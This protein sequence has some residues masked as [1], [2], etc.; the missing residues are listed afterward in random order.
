M[1]K[2]IKILFVVAII[3]LLSVM[4]VIVAACG[5]TDPD[6]LIVYTNSGSGGRSEWWEQQAAEA[7]FK[8]RVI[9][10][11][12]DAMKEK[13]IAE[14]KNPQADVM[15]GLNAMGWSDLKARDLL[16]QYVPSWA[17]DIDEGLN[18][19]DGYYHAIAK[20]SILLIYDKAVWTAEEA[21]KDWLD[22]W[23]DE[24][25][26]YHG[27]FQCWSALTG[28]TTQTVLAGIMYRFKSEA[29]DAKYGVSPQGWDE[30][31]RMYKYGVKAQGNVFDAISNHNPD[32]VNYNI[33]CGQWYSSGIKSYSETYYNKSKTQNLL[34]GVG[35]VLPEVGV[36]Y[37]ITGCGIIKG[38]KKEDLAKKFLDWYGGAEF[39]AKWAE[40]WNTAPANN[41]AWENGASE[42]AKMYTQLPQQYI[43]W[44][45]AQAHM[46]EWIQEIT[47]YLMN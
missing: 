43:D 4:S 2:S 37:A 40:K 45:W 7:G 41:T 19:A 31:K 42:D 30:L 10:G 46:G 8:I 27:T 22:L 6:T 14:A 17:D 39:Q 32:H 35:F 18:D 25:T 1:K 9:D 26:Q 29:A 28:G 3:A 34:Q 12:A 44:D 13:I 11:G 38:T 23:K 24:N 16:V 20:E 36:P 33:H 15:C 47:L 21:P 5:N